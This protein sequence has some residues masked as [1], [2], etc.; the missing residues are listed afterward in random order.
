MKRDKFEMKQNTNQIDPYCN[1]GNSLEN[2]TEK[3][4]GESSIQSSIQSSIW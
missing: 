1:K 4:Y 2:K 3:T